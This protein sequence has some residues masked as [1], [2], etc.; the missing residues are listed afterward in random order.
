MVFVN[1]VLSALFRLWRQQVTW[2]SN[3]RIMRNFI[4]CVLHLIFLWRWNVTGKMDWICSTYGWNVKIQQNFFWH[5]KSERVFGRLGCRWECSIRPGVYLA[6]IPCK[7]DPS[8]S[9]Y[10]HEEAIFKTV[11]N[12]L[13][14]WKKG[15]FWLTE[16]LFACAEW[17]RF[18]KL[19]AFWTVGY[20][21]KM[22]LVSA[23]PYI[24]CDKPIWNYH[25]FIRRWG[26]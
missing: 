23:Y 5:L 3:R 26:L 1:E 21:F 16:R 12:I 10:F 6:M 9:A 25:C 2:A 15:V 24:L 4:S 22:R 17:P 19:Y 11:V 20:V 7:L 8:L 18:M 14:L 13:F